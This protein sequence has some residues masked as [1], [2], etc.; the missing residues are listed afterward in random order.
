MRTRAHGEIYYEPPDRMRLYIFSVMGSEGD[1]GCNEKVFWF[2]S[3]RSK[4]PGIFYAKHEDYSKTRLKTPFNPL[5]IKASLGLEKVVT[6]D[7]KMYETE[8]DL[9]LVRE[10]RNSI[11]DRILVYTYLDK[12][13]Q[14]VRGQAITSLDGEMLAS[15]EILE[16][17]NRLPIKILYTWNE[18]DRN[19]LIELDRPTANVSLP[20]SLWEMPDIS[21]KIDMGKD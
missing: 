17:Y 16:R 13:N 15:S 20:A 4:E 2:W 12:E 14:W 19:M 10:S 9:V 11:G 6:K 5:W 3:R 8:K 18:E 21:P 7:A 1:V